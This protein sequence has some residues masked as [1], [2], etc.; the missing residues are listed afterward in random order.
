MNAASWPWAVF[1]VD[2]ALVLAAAGTAAYLLGS[3]SEG[4]SSDAEAWAEEARDLAREVQA[5]VSSVG[6]PADPDRVSRRLLPLSGRIRRHVRAAP[7]A[8]E[9]GTYRD[10]F[11]LGVACQRVALEHRPVGTSPDG[12]FL[13]ERLESLGD[14][15]AAL[16]SVAG[17]RPHSKPRSKTAKAT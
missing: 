3:R 7:A 17:D 15:A 10:L 2:A 16:E 11:D 12:V 8:V 9:E 5:V 6:R 1:L 4:G 13:E 14:A